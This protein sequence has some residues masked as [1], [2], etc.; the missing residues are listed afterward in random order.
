MVGTITDVD[1]DSSATNPSSSNFDT[2]SVFMVP[3]QDRDSYLSEITNT[4]ITVESI[5]DFEDLRGGQEA[6]C[7]VQTL[8][9]W[10]TSG[11]DLTDTISSLSQISLDLLYS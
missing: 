8:I 9:I 1:N 6:S 3:T 7:D 11:K 2:V 10:S 5:H 4:G